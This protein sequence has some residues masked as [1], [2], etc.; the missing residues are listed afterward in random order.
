MSYARHAPGVTPTFTLASDYMADRTYWPALRN[1]QVV[2]SLPKFSGANVEYLGDPLLQPIRS[3]EN[4]MLVRSLYKLSCVL[5]T[6]LAPYLSAIGTSTGLL[7]NLILQ[8]LAPPPPL[9]LTVSQ[10]TAREPPRTPTDRVSTV[11][12]PA[13]LEPALLEARAPRINLRPLASY[14][15]IS[16]LFLALLMIWVFRVPLWFTLFLLLSF[17]LVYCTLGYY[18]DKSAQKKGT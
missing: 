6:K 3:Y 10:R 17:L 16:Y 9:Q 7:S 1:E 15:T 5:N 2:Q 18:G 11:V 14:Y 4:P 13:L 8:L 12:P